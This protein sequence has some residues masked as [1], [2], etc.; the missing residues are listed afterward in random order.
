MPHKKRDRNW[1]IAAVV[2]AC[3]IGLFYLV[4]PEKPV[5]DEN[6]CLSDHPLQA[7][8]II[9]VDQTDPLTP[10]QAQYLI[11]R[12]SNIGKQSGS[13]ALARFEKLSLVKIVDQGNLLIDEKFSFCNP[14]TAKDANE[15]IDTPSWMERDFNNFFKAP[16]KEAVG[17]LAEPKKG[18]KRS[19]IFDTI[20]LTTLRKDFDASIA[21]RRLIIVSDMLENTSR[22]SHY[23][24]PFNASA[25]GAFNNE[26]FL[27]SLEGGSPTPNLNDIEV[28]VIY[29]HR[30]NGKGIQ[31]YAHQNFW[32]RLLS[33]FGAREVRFREQVPVK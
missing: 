14:G 30:E 32:Q 25:N 11:E 21:D 23:T 16:L 19:Y 22:F 33:S 28:E 26:R 17:R 3:S 6:M 5:L 12:I 8:T 2:M 13:D 24:P 4:M 29:L 10:F 18:L 20:A 7:H 31:S 9:L 15:L 1:V 27:R